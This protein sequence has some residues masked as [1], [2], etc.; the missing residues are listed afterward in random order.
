MS[1]PDYLLA[2]GDI[3]IATDRWYH[4]D[5][6]W[7][8]PDSPRPGH[9]RVGL[10]AYACRPG[11]EVY[12]VESLP[13]PGSQIREGDLLGVIETEKGVVSIYSPVDCQV[14][15]INEAILEDP[16]RIGFQNYSAWIL[17]LRPKS[18]PRL[19]SPS[20]YVQYLQSL[21]PPQCF[22]IRRQ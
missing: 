9:C 16:N 12:F 22:P 1:S 17:E 20:E 11:I 15:A 19:L 6:Y 5:H 21:P 8:L 18:M 7:I 4:R 10:S 14:L 3:R 2:P 13:T